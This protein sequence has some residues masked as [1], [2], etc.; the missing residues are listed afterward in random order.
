MSEINFLETSRR[1]VAISERRDKRAFLAFFALTLGVLLVLA[2]TLVVKIY[3]NNQNALVLARIEASKKQITANQDREQDF[4]VFYNKLGNL[5]ET[6]GR[7]HDGTELMVWDVDYFTQENVL[8]RS[9][10]YEMYGKQVEL[11]L[12]A[13]SV[14]YLQDVLDLIAAADFQDRYGKVENY[15]LNRDVEGYYNLTVSLALK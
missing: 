2:V 7:R 8:V 14:F 4:L 6:L 10:V 9:V 12:R 15:E 11:V 1:K 3:F 5:T 13:Y